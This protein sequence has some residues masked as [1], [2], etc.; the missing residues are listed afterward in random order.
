MGDISPWLMF[1]SEEV[2]LF[3]MLMTET[4]EFGRQGQG[5]KWT[6]M[7]SSYLMCE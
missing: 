6:S 3:T 7:N 1:L 5:N 2:A 4:A